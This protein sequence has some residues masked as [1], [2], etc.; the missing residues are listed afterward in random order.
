[1]NHTQKREMVNEQN[2]G[3]QQENET[4]KICEKHA[5]LFGQLLV[6]ENV[7]SLGRIIHETMNRIVES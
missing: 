2:W 3:L 7:M 4:S 6:S 5:C 1:M